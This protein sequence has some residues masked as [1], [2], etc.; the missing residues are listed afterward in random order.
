MPRGRHSVRLSV[1]TTDVLFVTGLSDV[2]F[3]PDAARCCSP[4]AA[5]ACQDTAECISFICNDCSATVQ[6]P[7]M[8]P[9]C[10]IETNRNAE[11]L[12]RSRP[13]VVAPM[14][15][16]PA[17]S[18]REPHV[19]GHRRLVARH[20]HLFREGEPAGEV[21]ELVDGV[22]ML[23][24]L[25]ADGRRSIVE[26]L[27]R[28]GDVFG[29]SST[30]VWD[31]AAQALVAGEVIAYDRAAVEQ[32]PALSRR[33]GARLQAQFCALHEHAVLL[34]RKTALE[35]VASFILRCIPGRGGFACSGPR[36]PDD[37]AH[38]RL[39]MTREE[40]ADY[41]GLTFET[42]SRIFSK[43][44]KRGVLTIDRDGQIVVRD[45]CE[46]CALTGAH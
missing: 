12:Q 18:R 39:G 11:N 44:R 2:F 6:A 9:A 13:L 28:T 33:I 4:D 19:R 10:R 46:L 30:P 38:V 32:S 42:V 40:I 45:V 43:L 5:A 7:P 27:I 20:A 23:Y 15:V 35:R 14:T 24:K 31:C 25:L 36:R 21:Y 3:R 1:E 22:V 8:R 34:G 17:L 29:V 16:L 41:L 37:S 26:V